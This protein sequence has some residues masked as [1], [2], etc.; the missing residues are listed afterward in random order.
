[1]GK[2]IKYAF[3]GW[4]LLSIVTAPLYWPYARMWW[5][6]MPSVAAGNYETPSSEAEA[7]RQ[8]ANFLSTLTKYDR[9][10]SDSARQSFETRI[11]EI[12]AAAD[13]LSAAE[14]YL[15][16]A[17]AVAFA[18]N[19]HTNVSI[20]PQHTEFRTI[21]ARLYRFRDGVHIVSAAPDKVPYLGRRVIAIDGTPIEALISD[22]GRYRGG[23]EAWRELHSLYIIESPELFAASGHGKSPDVLELTLESKAGILETVR[24]EGISPENPN[25]MDWRSAWQS[26]VP[27]GAT[28]GFKSWRHVFGHV[29]SEQLPRYLVKP[30]E[31]LSYALEGNGLYIR[32][33][34]GFKA[35]DQ[36]IQQAYKGMLAEYE[37]GSLDYLVVDFRL[38]DGGDYTKSMAF[39]KSAPQSVK[40]DGK[41]YIITGPNTFSAGIVTVAMLKYYSGERAMVIGEQMG[42]REQFWAERGSRFSLPNSGYSINYATGYHNWES[43]CKGDKYCYTMNVKHEVPAGSLA[44][45]A[46]IS[47]TFDSYQRGEDVVLDWIATQ[48]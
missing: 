4:L 26:L 47:Q 35:G 10:F 13:D 3:I 16:I 9:A 27:T 21:G 23:N 11:A 28:K 20:Y 42:D 15:S 1:M 34:P 37:V 2:F 38:H 30:S 39:A 18:D 12:E 44:T 6:F 36:S 22:L 25:D 19:G 31:P 29:D 46:E 7:R 40:P 45:Q 32:A 8:D 48:H 17:E 14:F 41:V 33:L 43:G 24:F 5:V